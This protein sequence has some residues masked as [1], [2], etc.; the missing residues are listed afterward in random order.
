M[1]VDT[2][3]SEMDFIRIANSITELPKEKK[4]FRKIQRLFDDRRKMV[5][6]KVFDWAMAELM[7]YGTLLD[8]GKRV[9]ISGQDVKRGTF[10][11]RHAVLTLEDSEE[12]YVPLA[13]LNNGAVKFDIYN[14]LLSEYGVL[15]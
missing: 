1:P 13:K 5:K 10:S 6:E 11:H 8:E 4:F 15:G 9:R 14:S 7:A 12:E 2:T 3:V